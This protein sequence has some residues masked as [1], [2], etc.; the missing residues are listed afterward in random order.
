MSRAYRSAYTKFRSGV[1]PILI[2]T[3][4]Y[5]RLDCTDRTCFNCTGEV[6]NENMFSYNHLLRESMFTN[7][8][9]EFPNIMTVVDNEKLS[10]I[11]S[12]QSFHSILNCAKIRHFISSLLYNIYSTKKLRKLCLRGYNK[13]SKTFKYF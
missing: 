8:S 11:F 7:T 4:R 1:A 5:E 3:S 10:G 9:L 12:C 2:D 13:I 6:E